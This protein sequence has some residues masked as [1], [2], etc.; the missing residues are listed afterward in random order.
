MAVS[1]RSLSSTIG[2]ATPLDGVEAPRV[3]RADCLLAG[4]LTEARVDDR[5]S[6]VVEPAP[7]ALFLVILCVSSILSQTC[8][9]AN[10]EMRA[11]DVVRVS[12]NPF[13]AFSFFC[14]RA[15]R[16]THCTAF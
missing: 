14:V 10:G 2:V 6:A 11:R 1:M 16:A 8:K 13:L 15:K 9:C 3:R 5:L 4:L 7:A 12:V